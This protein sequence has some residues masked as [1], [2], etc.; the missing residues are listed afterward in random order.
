[1]VTV[2]AVHAG[3]YPVK[4]G[5]KGAGHT[6]GESNESGQQGSKDDRFHMQS[7]DGQYVFGHTTGNQVNRV[8]M[9]LNWMRKKSEEKHL[10]YAF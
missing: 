9:R 8:L 6:K 4:A 3:V 7:S 5:N 2:V 10:S 1:M